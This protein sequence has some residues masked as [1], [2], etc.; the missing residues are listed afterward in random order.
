MELV[1]DPRAWLKR[2]KN[3]N[4]YSIFHLL[5]SDWGLLYSVVEVDPSPSLFKVQSKR[6]DSWRLWL[7]EWAT[8]GNQPW[9]K[10]R[11]EA[12]Q[13]RG[14]ALIWQSVATIVMTGVKGSDG[15]KYNLRFSFNSWCPSTNLHQTDKG[16]AKWY[17]HLIHN[18]H[19]YYI[20]LIRQSNKDTHVLPR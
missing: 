14:H 9:G 2:K 13:K 20:M 7:C 15:L 10:G 16:S 19:C 18:M 11:D 12:D 5:N 6:L 1:S 8:S 3:Q 17:C 4:Y